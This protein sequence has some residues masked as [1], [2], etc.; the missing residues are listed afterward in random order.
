MLTP[1]TVSAPLPRRAGGAQHPGRIRG[2]Q[3]HHRDAGPRGAVRT[4]PRHRPA[5][6][7]ARTF[8]DAALLLHRGDDRQQGRFVPLE[9]TLDSCERILSGEFAD[10]DE[11]DFYMI[12]TV[13]DLTRGERRRMR[14][15]VITPWRVFCVRPPVRR[16]VAEGPDGLRHAAR[17]CRFRQPLVPGILLYETDDGA[18]RF[19]RGQFRH[20]GQM[21]RRCARGGA[22]RGRGR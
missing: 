18:E 21:R 8:P 20:A 10:R 2:A 5:G 4:R 17:P 15:E 14:L 3:G 19:R 6:P 1:G 22:R 11:G 16:I 7:P 13:D 9:E 12:G